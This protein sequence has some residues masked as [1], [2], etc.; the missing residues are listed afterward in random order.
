MIF[1]LMADYRGEGGVF[2]L[3]SL[4]LHNV[5]KKRNYPHFKGIIR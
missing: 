3:I 1:I 5:R 4:L 2:A